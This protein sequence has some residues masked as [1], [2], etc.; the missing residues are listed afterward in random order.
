MQTTNGNM[1]VAIVNLIDVTFRPVMS[2]PWL[3]NSLRGI[4]GLGPISDRY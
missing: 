2:K 3:W 4:R 1:K